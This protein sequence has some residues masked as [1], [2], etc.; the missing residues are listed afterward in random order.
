MNTAAV[1]CTGVAKAFGSTI[2]VDGVDLTVERGQVLA[3][4]GPSGCGK[5]TLLRL[6][7]GLETPDAGSVE[8]GGRMVATPESSLAPEKRSAGMV[9][10]DFALFPHMSVKGNIAYGLPR[11]SDRDGRVE[12]MV[13][14]TG[15]RGLADRMPHELSGGQQQR[16]ALARALAPRPQVLLLD[17][18]FSNLDPALRDQVRRDTAEILKAGGATCVFVTHSRED[19][20]VIGDEIA[21]MH[22]GRIEQV[23]TPERIFHAP[24]NRFVAAFMGLADFIPAIVRDG[25]I[26]TELGSAPLPQPAPDEDGLEAMVRP[27]DVVLR[28]SETGSGVIVERRF[29][30]AF[31]LYRMALDS[32]AVV[33]SLG[34]HAHPLDV[35]ARVEALLDAA[36]PPLA[37]RDGLAAF[38]G[39]APDH[40]PLEG[41]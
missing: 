24:S 16:V 3:L 6:I 41:R 18:P 34:S 5:T 21:L 2:A 37:F 32:G 19:A 23:D 36:H 39:S 30:G 40:A 31:Y 20:M 22:R 25:A 35:G 11:G 8:V 9:F 17:E 29:Q 33:H 15:L 10:Q 4:L 26:R 1:I 7:A 28:P 14:L 12:E 13:A 38:A 27:D